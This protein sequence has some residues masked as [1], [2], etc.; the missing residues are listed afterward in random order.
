MAARASATYDMVLKDKSSAGRRGFLNSLDV[1][2][3][4]VAALAVGGFAALAAGGAAAFTSL[5]NAQAPLIDQLGKMAEKLEISATSLQAMIDA[6]E[7]ADVPIATLEKSLQKMATNASDAAKGSG[8]ALKAFDELGLS[9]K[10]LN[11]LSVDEQFKRISDALAGVSNQNDKLRLAEDVFGARGTALIRLT[12]EAINQ[13]ETEMR[14]LDIALTDINVD[15]VEELNDAL[16]KVGRLSTGAKQV[17]IAELAP[18]LRAVLEETLLAGA[19]FSSVRDIGIAAGEGIVFAFGVVGDRI[20][21]VKLIL[22][23]INSLLATI[24]FKGEKFKDDFLGGADPEL[25]REYRR[26][27]L[28]ATNEFKLARIEQ[29]FSERLDERFA[30]IKAGMEAAREE[31]ERLRT[32]IEKPIGGNGAITE[33]PSAV[34]PAANDEN[35]DPD[36]EVRASLAREAEKARIKEESAIAQQERDIDRLRE[37]GL[38]EDQL[39][40]ERQQRTEEFLDSVVAKDISRTDEINAIKQ[41]ANQQYHDQ[42]LAI[43]QRASA[44]RLRLEAAQEQAS[45][46]YLERGIAFFAQKSEAAD[47]LHK[48]LVARRMFREGREAVIGAYKWG[49]SI[50]GPFLGGVFA[51]IAGAY[52]AALIAE[53]VGGS[54]SAPAAPAVGAIDSDPTTY[55]TVTSGTQSQAA[56]QQP[57]TVVYNAY[58]PIG[59]AAGD[60]ESVARQQFDEDVKA[61][62][63]VIGDDV[64]VQVNTFDY[65]EFGT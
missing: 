62:R 47:V 15:N 52:T 21:N 41:A 49:N 54:S 13:A 8:E 30:A 14:E 10:E 46:S 22:S 32:E 24:N 29:P 37:F 60:R 50:G 64:E 58:F 51:G 65:E 11:D 9:A 7:R 31:Q 23:G 35:V 45:R 53:T 55:G 39:L 2:D 56:V 28:S 16:Q 25:L 40:I 44:E 36:A 63:I 34:T 38:R 12:S 19:G 5:Y 4:K 26:E 20:Q 43:A 17:F 6:G 61:K 59:V 18:A 57:Q 1:I 42:Y 33:L 48:A 27:Y 3:G